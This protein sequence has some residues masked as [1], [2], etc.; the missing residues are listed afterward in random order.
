MALGD[1]TDGFTF[2]LLVEAA[3]AVVVLVTYQWAS[4]RLRGFLGQGVVGGMAHGAVGGNEGRHGKEGGKEGRKGGP[5]ATLADR[6]GMIA[7]SSTAVSVGAF[8]V[9]VGNGGYFLGVCTL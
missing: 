1:P 2:F 4:R 7:R 9:L 6:M 5:S 8:L 3:T